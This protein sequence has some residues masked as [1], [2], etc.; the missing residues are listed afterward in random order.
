[1]K[2]SVLFLKE[3][4]NMD[5]IFMKQ[6]LPLYL[7]AAKL[8]LSIAVKGILLSI[9]LG[10]IS[11]LIRYFKIPILQKITGVYIELSRNTPLLIQLFFLYFGLPKLGIF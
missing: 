1:V 7:E 11:S 3:R 10:L 5:I 6:N 9:I 4:G 8:T 2:A